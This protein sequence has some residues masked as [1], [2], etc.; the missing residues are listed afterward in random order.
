MLCVVCCANEDNVPVYKCKVC[1]I[2]VHEIC[3]GTI[4]A[5]EKAEFVCTRCSKSCKDIRCELCVRTSGA[6]KP[7]VNKK[8]VHVVCALFIDGVVFQDKYLMEPVDIS[9]VK[10]NKNAQCSVCI[11][12]GRKQLVSEG[13]L[14]KCAFHK[15]NRYMHVTCAQI[16]IRRDTE[17]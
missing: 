16:I 11:H 14:L 9:K 8:W 15:C 6:F 2:F 4:C 1:C 3:Y 17:R 13:Y 10:F 7:T 5:D 12:N